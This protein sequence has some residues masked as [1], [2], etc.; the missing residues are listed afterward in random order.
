MQFCLSWV[1]FCFS[2]SVFVLEMAHLTK[3]RGRRRVE[4]QTVTS[5]CGEVEIGG[6]YSFCPLDLAVI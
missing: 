1:T 2:V 6:K 4:K 3:E 5:E